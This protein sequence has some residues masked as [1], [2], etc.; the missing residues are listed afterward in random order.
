M[1]WRIDAREA[2]IREKMTS[3]DVVQEL[4]E[5]ELVQMGRKHVFCV[6][7]SSAFLEFVRV[8]LEEANYNIT[9]TNFVPSTFDQ[10]VALDPDLLII[11]LEVGRRAGFDLLERLHV[12][13][14]TS[15]IP[16]IVVSTDARLLDEARNMS[17]I[18][19]STLFI[20]KPFNIDDLLCGVHDL[21]GDA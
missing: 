14:S 18:T 16:L 21:I 20:G 19:S 4:T 3:P 15:S 6:N 1:L 13:A 17:S 11:D 8:L 2:S 5:R 12:D 9:T 10:I 7:G